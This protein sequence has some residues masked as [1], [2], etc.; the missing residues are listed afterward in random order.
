VL[1]LEVWNYG[2]LYDNLAV[3]FTRK[4]LSST[5]ATGAQGSGYARG[6]VLPWNV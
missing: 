1:V 3:D 2:S 4:P 6:V 5:G